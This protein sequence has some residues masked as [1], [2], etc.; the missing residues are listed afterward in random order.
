M[1]WNDYSFS[2]IVNITPVR[3]FFNK[4]EIKTF[5]VAYTYVYS[6]IDFMLSIMWKS[7]IQFKNFPNLL[8]YREYL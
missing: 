6:Q 1:D 7:I 2:Q 4:T 8:N 3:N 5:K